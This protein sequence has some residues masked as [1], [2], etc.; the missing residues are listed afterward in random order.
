MKN[1]LRSFLTL[2]IICS[3]TYANGQ[4]QSVKLGVGSKAPEL[5]VSWLKGT[6]VTS[7][8]GDMLYVVEFWATWCGPC[9]SAMPHLSELAKRYEGKVVFIGVDV[10]EKGF[11]TKSYDSFT[12][13]LKEFVE[14]MGNKMAYNV[15]MDNNDLYMAKNWM[16]ASG[17]QGIPASFIIKGGQ[18]VWIGH[19]H[20]IEKTIDELLAGT[21][22]MTAF[23][24]KFNAERKRSMEQTEPLIKLMKSVEESVKAKD[25]SKALNDI[26]NGLVTIDPVFKIAV[27][28]LKFTT[29]LQHN[30]QEG[31][32]FAQE[33]AKEFPGAK[34][35]IAMGIITLD[36]LD[37]EAYL[38]AAEYFKEMLSQGGVKP[39]I[40]HIIAQSYAKMKDFNNAILSEKQAIET[41][42]AAIAA[43][44]HQGTINNS[45]IKEYETALAGYEA[46]SKE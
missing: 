39:M 31:L 35:T 24:E 10:W 27:N 44:E 16:E 15:A 30:P 45:T 38:L 26:E 6:P 8:D 29:L 40:H 43:V 42:K 20:V 11:Q 22:N 46:A 37:K 36:G 1:L 19:P 17:Q 32:K 2:L 5:R 41:A 34:G 3:I 21:Y 12:P 9:K 4:D 7:F 13:M 25:F 23:A 28:S 18:I 14:G 33:W